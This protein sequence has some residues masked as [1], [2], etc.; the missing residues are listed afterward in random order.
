LILV[1]IDYLRI[2]RLPL[3]LRS[4]HFTFPFLT[5]ETQQFCYIASFQEYRGI[6]QRGSDRESAGVPQRGSPRHLPDFT[7]T[8]EIPIAS[9]RETFGPTVISASWVFGIDAPGDWPMAFFS[10]DPDQTGI[11]VPQISWLQP[12]DL[13]VPAPPT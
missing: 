3:E 13:L 10:L 4:C 8:G 11:G 7:Q 12:H 2:F 1:I 9:Y 6:D 5:G